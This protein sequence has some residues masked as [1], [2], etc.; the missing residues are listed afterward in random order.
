MTAWRIT[1]MCCVVT[2][3]VAGPARAQD[4]AVEAEAD[5]AALKAKY[6]GLR[7]QADEVRK[8]MARFRGKYED[9]PEVA[10]AKTAA[11]KAYEDYRT[12]VKESAAIAAARKAVDEAR[13]AFEAEVTAAML[14][15]PNAGPTVKKY[16]ANRK[17]IEQLKKEYEEA[18]KLDRQMRKEVGQLRGKFLRDR[19]LA[20]DAR[21]AVAAAEQ[22]YREAVKADQAVQAAYKTSAE[23]REAYEKALQ[24][25]LETDSD[26]AQLSAKHKA[27]AE[28]MKAV[29]EQMRKRPKRSRKP[30]EPKGEAAEPVI[31]G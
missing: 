23:A 1:V 8:E 22:G 9:A 4:A 18:V 19:E 15:D 10:E 26:Y 11:Q 14:A 2:A 20:K 27:L 25:K 17:R 29:R 7:K 12:A 24:A 5:R 6:D 16:E 30:A 31:E 3:A 28:E 13:E 21:E